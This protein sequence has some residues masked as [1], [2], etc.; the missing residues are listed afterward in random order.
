MPK[1]RLGPI[2][3]ATTSF[4]GCLGLVVAM[5]AVSV[6]FWTWVLMVFMGVGGLDWGF[7]KVLVPWG[8]IAPLVLGG[9]QALQR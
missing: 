9:T 2:A 5:Y 3:L 4:G 6:L 8:L 1:V 7:D